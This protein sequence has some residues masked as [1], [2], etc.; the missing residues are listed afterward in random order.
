M[1]F[2]IVLVIAIGILY[3]FK[4]K[5]VQKDRE[6]E[7]QKHKREQALR[8]AKQKKEDRETIAE[9]KEQIERLNERL[10]ERDDDI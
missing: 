2:I 7:M 9:L 10:D 4:Q 5:G 3:W 6:I 8:E 1:N